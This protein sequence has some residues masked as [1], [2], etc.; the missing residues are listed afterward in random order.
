[1]LN[2]GWRS[3]SRGRDVVVGYVE[4]YDR[5]NTRSQIRDLEVLP[6]AKLEYRGQ[7]FEE[8]DLDRCCSAH[9]DVALVDSWPTP[10]FPGSRH[11][12]RWQDVEELL[13][14]GINVIRRSTS[15]TSSR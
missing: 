10:T 6:R 12:K 2:E 13:E 3:H 7:V 15:S 1:M 5:P 8:M 11:K 14:A 4:T 9:P